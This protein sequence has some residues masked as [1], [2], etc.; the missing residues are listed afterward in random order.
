MVKSDD[1]NKEK[2]WKKKYFDSL[3]EL[4]NS[5]KDWGEIEELLRLGISRLTLIAE[6][7]ENK[8]LN[9]QVLL[10]R[11]SIREGTESKRLVLLIEN[12]SDD[13]KKLPDESNKNFTKESSDNQSDIIALLETILDSIISNSNQKSEFTKFQKKLNKADIKNSEE[14]TKEFS[15]LIINL[16]DKNDTN[17]NTPVLETS[18]KQEK[19]SESERR[20]DNRVADNLDNDIDR[21]IDSKN[22]SLI[23]PAVG[24]LILQLMTRFP[25]SFS[26]VLN[27]QALA[28]AASSARN[29]KDLLQI[30]DKISQEL[31]QFIR[32]IS[33][34]ETD[35]VNSNNES[36]GEV[37]IHLLQQISLPDYLSEQAIKLKQ[38]IE[39]GD[40]ENSVTNMVEATA[41]LIMQ[42]RV[43]LQAEKQELEQF[44]SEISKH[45]KALDIDIQVTSRLRDESA[46][47]LKQYDE[48]LEN[49]VS[50]LETGLNETI[51]LEGLKDLV[52]ERVKTIRLHMGVFRKSEEHRN[53]SAEDTIKK[54]TNR[55]NDMELETT[56]LREQV[57]QEHNSAV[58]DVLTKIP[59]RLAYEERIA[60][61]IERC[62]R[63]KSS[64]A[65]VVW[66][67]D[68]FKG[69]NDHYGHIAGDKVLTVIA[70]VL[71]KN[72]RAADFIARYGGEEFVVIMPETDLDMAEKGCEKIRLAIENCNFHYRDT[73]VPI[74]ASCGFTTYQESD[75]KDI[76]FDRADKALYKAKE[77]GRNQCVKA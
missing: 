58:R 30:V 77:N 52:K 44:L 5:E 26:K 23:A 12:I 60:A 76:L 40:P 61:E 51:E 14:L 8:K 7:T 39:K 22:N 74:T 66:D 31:S 72:L 32:K 33:S 25:P 46:E 6:S 68:H 73:S 17:D 47:S 56:T 59:N 57:A 20:I 24:E 36:D 64:M 29:R 54:L 69:I 62:K 63:Y 37:L 4:E 19:E 70:E 11:K 45:L 18:T 13:I 3:K 50:G 53:N 27:G 38:D 43:R 49:E 16:I 35:Q 55:I 15:T 65:F 48:K 10:L 2:D 41:D 9:D 71:R 1:A 67:I 75:T 42:M 21:S 34:K 28:R